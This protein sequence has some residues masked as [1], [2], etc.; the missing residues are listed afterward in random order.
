MLLALLVAV[1]SGLLSGTVPAQATPVSPV[2]SIITDP[3]PLPLGYL[4]LTPDEAGTACHVKTL[5]GCEQAALIVRAINATPC[6]GRITATF[7]SMSIDAYA[8]ALVA[9]EKCGTDLHILT[10]HGL[11][12]DGEVIKDS[13]QLRRV[14]SAV[15]KY[16]NGWYKSCR[17]SCYDRRAKGTMHMKEWLF[18]ST[19]DQQDVIIHSENNATTNGDLVHFGSLTVLSDPCAYT[20]LSAWI[21]LGRKDKA[22]TTPKPFSTCDG[23]RT[24]HVAPTKKNAALDLLKAIK[25]P[26]PGCRVEHDMNQVTIDAPTDQVVRLHKAGC[27]TRAVVDW[28]LFS[29]GVLKSASQMKQIRRLVAAGVPTFDAS[30]KPTAYN[31]RKAT[32]AQNGDVRW[33]ASGA[34]NQTKGSFKSANILLVSRVGADVTAAFAASDVMVAYSHQLTLESVGCVGAKKKQPA[35]CT[36]Q[37]SSASKR[38]TSSKHLGGSAGSADPGESFE[39][40]ASELGED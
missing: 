38:A 26:A 34:T 15:K 13:E 2:D 39:Q 33:A 31:H 5:D 19:G 22:R 27:Q 8:D 14:R 28:K 20:A 35:G 1:L 17:Y 23:Q 3:G 16:G 7:Y 25:E 4:P 37:H 21:D 11:D 10:W 40:R 18:S 12:E 36:S 32:I 30:W 6:T 29:Q 24:F 9:R